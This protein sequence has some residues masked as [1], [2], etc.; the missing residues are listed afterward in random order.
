MSGDANDEPFRTYLGITLGTIAVD[1]FF[2]T[3][4]FLITGSLRR[5]RSISSFAWAR[6]LRIYPALLVAMLL[7]VLVLGP[8]FTTLP[9]S[10]YFADSRTFAYLVRGGTLMAGVLE[11]LPGVFDG[12]PYPRVVNGSLW[13]LPH[14]VRLYMALAGLWVVSRIVSRWLPSAFALMLIGLACGSGLVVAGSTIAGIEMHPLLRLGYM[15][16]AGASFAV[17][18]GKVAFPRSRLVALLAILAISFPLPRVFVTAYSLAI[19]CLTLLVAFQPRTVRAARPEAGDYSYG[20]YIYAFPVQQ[21]IIALV[22]PI[23][24]LNLLISSAIV[25]F[26]LAFLSWHLIERRAIALKTMFF[27]KRLAGSS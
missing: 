4:G 19:P 13:T 14:E 23:P 15:F 8:T 27:E 9:L 20:V 3:S 18:R 21:S 25:T 11:S 24:V 1:V 10:S 5:A 22:G 7:S 6:V 26:A 12:N 2:V 17:L 16:S